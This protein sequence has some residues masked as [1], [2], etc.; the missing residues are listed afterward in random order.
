VT[1]TLLV[2]CRALLALGIYLAC[3]LPALAQPLPKVK[4]PNLL[5]NREESV[6]IKAKI[7]RYPWAVALLEHLKAMFKDRV[8]AHMRG[9]LHSAIAYVL[10]DGKRYAAAARKDLLHTANSRLPKYAAA[11]LRLSPAFGEFAPVANWAWSYE[12]LPHSWWIDNERGRSVDATWQADWVQKSAG[13]TRGIQ[14][15][16]PQWFDQTVGVRMTMLGRQGTEVCVGNGP[17]TD[18]PPYHRLD[19]NAEGSSPLVIA[20]R[21][22]AATT[23]AAIHQPYDRAA[24]QTQVRRLAEGD[25]FVAAA[26]EKGD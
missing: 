15:F 20:R 1:K 16:G 13:V 7:H 3:H 18:G 12:L 22:D 23:F 4:H 8:V 26:V 25:E 24:P 2:S 10:T 11:D 19:G 6:Q 21:H 9:G 5:L 14:P 17:I